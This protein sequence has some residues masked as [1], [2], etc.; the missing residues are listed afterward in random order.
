MSDLPQAL[1]TDTEG[2]SQTSA[3]SFWKPDKSNIHIRYY[4]MKNPTGNG[5]LTEG[6]FDTGSGWKANTATFPQ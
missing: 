3:V 4:Q 1:I 6:S 5:V 2:S